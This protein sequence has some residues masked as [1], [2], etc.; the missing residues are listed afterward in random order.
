LAVGSRDSALA[1]AVTA[2]AYTIQITTP[3]NLQGVGLAELYELDRNG[4]TVNLSTRA[5]V[6]TG[7]GVLI[8][9]FVVQGP[10]Y[11]RML[12]RGVGPT[13][14]AFGLSG[15]LLDPIVTIYSGQTVVAT[16]D[17]WEA[18]ENA[19]GIAS[20]T[21]AVGAFTL[22][23]NSQDAALLITLPPGAYTVEVKGKADSEGVALLEI[24]DVP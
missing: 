24:Y 1:D 23:A 13:L 20:A 5:Q 8:G 21:K 12:V 9:G 3:S 17:K 4:R 6:R 14:A 22:A 7:D 11:K 18:A 19:A 16:N 2:G 10:A 15:A